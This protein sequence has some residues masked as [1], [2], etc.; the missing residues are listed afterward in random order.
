MELGK[1]D[2]DKKKEA[3]HCLKDYEKILF[4]GLFF[5]ENLQQY[6]TVPVDSTFEDDKEKYLTTI[7]KKIIDTEIENLPRGVENQIPYFTFYKELNQFR[8]AISDK[9]NVEIEIGLRDF[10]ERLKKFGFSAKGIP[11]NNPKLPYQLLGSQGA[12]RK[13]LNH[14]NERLEIFF[15]FLIEDAKANGKWKNAK[16]AVEHVFP[17]IVEKFEIHTQLKMLEALRDCVDRIDQFKY[18]IEEA[19]QYEE[20][21][22][23]LPLY[24]ERMHLSKAVKL[25][26]EDQLFLL[27]LQR[28]LNTNNITV[29]LKKKLKIAYEADYSEEVL[30]RNLRK[31]KALL[32]KIIDKEN[33]RRA[34]RY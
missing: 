9:N 11:L 24:G 13:K 21:K 1:A 25:L 2:K 12:D 6:F 33:G 28:A 15:D 32:E 29:E 5:A 14:Y 8:N 27:Q 20:G 7:K 22:V 26:K 3:L 23:D 4:E 18:A 30:L 17:I 31:N 16:Q 19:I 10:F 34:E